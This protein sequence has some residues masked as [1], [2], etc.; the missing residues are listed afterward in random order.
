MDDYE[1][2][3][4]QM[5]DALDDAGAAFREMYDFKM[6]NKMSEYRQ[7]QAGWVRAN[8]RFSSLVKKRDDLIKSV[9]GE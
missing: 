7:A 1:L 5:R 3:T 8:Q 4:K 6:K 9:L 2:L